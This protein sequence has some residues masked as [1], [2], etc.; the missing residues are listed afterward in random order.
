MMPLDL[1]RVLP[2][3]AGLQQHLL[4]VNKVAPAGKDMCST[5][6]ACILSS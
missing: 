1:F 4:H 2:G 5:G 3:N 6:Q